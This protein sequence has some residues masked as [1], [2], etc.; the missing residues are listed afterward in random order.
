MTTYERVNP[1]TL[2]LRGFSGSASEVSD[3][4]LSPPAGWCLTGAKSPGGWCPGPNSWPLTCT[5]STSRG[6]EHTRSAG[7]WL[8]ALSTG[9]IWPKHAVLLL[10]SATVTSNSPHVTSLTI[11]L[12]LLRPCHNR[13]YD[14]SY[15][16]RISEAL[17]DANLGF[18]RVNWQAVLLQWN[19][20]WNGQFVDLINIKPYM[21][22][23]RLTRAGVNRDMLAARVPM[24]TDM[25]HICTS[26]TQHEL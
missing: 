25:T 22:V 24:M 12:C 21:S 2:T 19:R 17:Q 4:S 16:L 20:K 7:R 5:S 13:A 1:N 23:T 26:T 15:N 3:V 9:R 11:K 6:L 14:L 18:R 8:V 10:R